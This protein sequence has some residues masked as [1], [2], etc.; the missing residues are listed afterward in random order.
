MREPDYPAGVAASLTAE[1]GFLFLVVAAMSLRGKSPWMSPR[2]PATLIVG[3]RAV[4]PPG[5]VLHDIVL[6]LLMH[7]WLAV[8][9]GMLYA[10][11][12][13]RLGVSPVVGGLIT[14]G[15]LYALGF[16]MLPAL[17]SEWLAPFRLPPDGSILQAVLHGLYGLLFGWAFRAARE[18]RY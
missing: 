18:I 2:M 16:W 4:H 5:F 9:V 11:L 17:F 8:L 13:P 12:R 15:I 14:A 3:P 1:V 7:L 6:G 10:A